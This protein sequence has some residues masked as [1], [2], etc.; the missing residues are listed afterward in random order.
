MNAI[1]PSAYVDPKSEVGDDVRIGPNCYVGSSVR[2]GDGC[3]L[4]NNVTLTGYTRVG[5]RCEFF[6]GCVIGAEPQDLKY[7]GEPSE[8][9]IGSDN[10]F[11]ELTT[12]HPGTEAGGGV[13]T[14]GDHNRFLVGV[15]IAHDV[16]IEDNCVL[17]NN[18]QLGGHVHVESYATFGGVAGVHHFVTIGR[19]SFVAALAR[20]A[21]DVP[22][23]MIM[24]GY[25]SRVRGVNTKALARWGFSPE[26]IAALKRAYLDLYTDRSRFGGPVVHRLTA[27]ESDGQLTDDVR[28][29]ILSVRRTAIDGHL[30][31]FLESRRPE[32]TR[33]RAGFYD[34]QLYGEKHRG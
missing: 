30:G 10:V 6:P 17:A 31:R 11:R 29:L 9:I 12:A 24:Q 16:L 27:M 20:I 7:H 34:E 25:E 1:H 2:L 23:F 21:T 18:V 22:P 32:A 19:Y 28:H 4:H 26:R 14:I 5:P 33:R 13:T 8:L 15:H 3:R